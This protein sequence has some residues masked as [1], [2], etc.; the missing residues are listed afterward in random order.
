LR[1][2]LLKDFELVWDHVEPGVEKFDR[3]VYE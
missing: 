1:E 3:E 2:K